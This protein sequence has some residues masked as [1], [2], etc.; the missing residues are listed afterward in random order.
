M[1]ARRAEREGQVGRTLDRPGRRRPLTPEEREGVVA[2]VRELKRMVIPPLQRVMQSPDPDP[3]DRESYHR[4]TNELDW[5]LEAMD[6]SERG[7]KGGGSNGHS[8]NHDPGA[9]RTPTTGRERRGYEMN[10]ETYSLH[11]GLRRLWTDHVVWTRSYVVAAVA[12]APDAE[13]AAER[14][15][16]NQ[17]DIG[18]AVVPFYGQEAGDA[19]ANLLK[20]H[21]M[22]AVGLIAAAKAG[23]T[24]RFEEQ[25]SLWTKNAEEIAELLSG[26]NPNWPKDDVVDILGI[27]LRLT[28]DEAVARMEGNWK[29]DVEAFDQ[30]LTEI[31]TLSDVLADGIV[32]QFPDRFGE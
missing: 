19:L 25:D 5:L 28:K 13:T 2:R 6:H 9:R 10:Q 27:H 8:S 12:D 26:A 23:D 3:T 17:E 1:T 24:T 14:L 22:I 32:K 18:A 15:L 31:L 29:A 30:I 16:K 11:S 4:A 20:Q 21:I 7:G